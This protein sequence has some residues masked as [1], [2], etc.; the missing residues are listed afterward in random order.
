MT[1][2]GTTTLNYDTP[3]IGLT[4]THMETEES[5]KALWSNLY[6]MTTM[7]DNEGR[8]KWFHFKASQNTPKIK[9]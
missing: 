3:L 2:P 5:D 6:C 7:N 4:D 8:H 1:T 9:M